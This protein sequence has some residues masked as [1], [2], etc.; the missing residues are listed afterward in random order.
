MKRIAA[1]WM[2]AI[3]LPASISQA[4]VFLQVSS[5]SPLSHGLVS[6]T[7]RGVSTAGEIIH[8]VSNPT[9][10]PNVGGMGLHQVWTPV[11]NSPTPTR[12]SQLNI[13]PLWSDTWRPYDSYFFFGPTFFLERFTE[14]N[15]MSGG[16]PLPTAGFGSPVTGFGNYG[17]MGPNATR[18]VETELQD[19]NV[20]LA[21]L[22]VKETESVL[23]SLALVGNFG[24]R[25]L[26]DVCVGCLP[27]PLSVADRDLG[28][29][30]RGE[31]V[32]AMLAAST[33]GVEWSLQSFT[34]PG[35]NVPGASVDPVSGEFQWDTSGAPLGPYSA[36][37]HGFRLDVGSDTGELTFNLIPEPANLTPFAFAAIVTFSFA[38]RR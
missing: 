20:D 10:V 7:L 27:L 21:Q 9:I 30:T 1:L 3:L 14:T 11:T 22:V 6:Y 37:I 36:V 23:V 38:R 29:V 15:S 25:T 24:S 33:N 19:T 31:L 13:V 17:Y 5:P 32:T 35:G 16:A 12:G 8:G 34:G 28:E 4:G 2:S 26:S 18:L